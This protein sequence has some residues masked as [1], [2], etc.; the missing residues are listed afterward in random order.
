LC[1]GRLS[2]VGWRICG[3]VVAS[4]CSRGAVSAITSVAAVASI[5]TVTA[6]GS[7]AF[8]S[9][10]ATIAVLVVRGWI[11]WRFGRWRCFGVTFADVFF[12]FVGQFSSV[13]MLWRANGHSRDPGAEWFVGFRNF[14]SS[15][16]CFVGSRQEL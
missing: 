6:F 14:G 16:F 3:A 1:G 7:F 9:M 4:F 8:G 12:K 15:Q 2:E 11:A 13:G 10:I 5:A